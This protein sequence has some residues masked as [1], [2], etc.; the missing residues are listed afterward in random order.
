MYANFAP[1]YVDP[2]SVDQIKH[3]IKIHKMKRVKSLDQSDG[4]PKSDGNLVKF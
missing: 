2:I 1:I 3:K 4:G